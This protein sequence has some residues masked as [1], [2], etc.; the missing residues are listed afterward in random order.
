MSQEGENEK[1]SKTRSFDS[2]TGVVK[3]LVPHVLQV[4]FQL[5]RQSRVHVSPN[6]LAYLLL[7]LVTSNTVTS[8]LTK[9]IE[10]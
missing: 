8:V 10:I 1:E 7:V 4:V 6:R 3:L 9:V 5:H 2:S